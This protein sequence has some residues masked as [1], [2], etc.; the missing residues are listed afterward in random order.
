MLHRISFAIG[1][2]ALNLCTV[3]AATVDYE[4]QWH[5]LTFNSTG[6]ARA[7]V[8][9]TLP[10]VSVSLDLDG[11]V[12]GGLNP[13]PLVLSGIASPDG[14]VAFT[15]INGHATYGDVTAST[16]TLGVLTAACANVPG[17]VSTV[18]LTGTTSPALIDLTYD[19]T[20]DTG[21]TGANG[22]VLM[23]A[24]PEPTSIAALTTILWVRRRRH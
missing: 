3:R 14:S 8:T 17:Q 20:F 24:I 6:A 19:I 5:N 9:K 13:A 2:F 7:T 11:N 21:S 18:L 1:L 10:A 12:F 16:S 22:T 15:P 4:G 23:R